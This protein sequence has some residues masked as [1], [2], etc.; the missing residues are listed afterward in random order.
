MNKR[1]IKTKEKKW[2]IKNTVSE[3]SALKISEI[4]ESLGINPIIANLLYGRG[5]QDVVSA[6]KFLYMESEILTDPYSMVDMKPAVER[7]AE[8]IR[9]NEKI[10]IYGDY[11]VDGVTSVC[12]L[13]LY[14]KSY[15]ADVNYY[16]PN[17]IGDG[18]G[19]SEAAISS[20]A[21]EGTKLIIT[22]D[23]GIT[24]DAEV[25]FAKTVGVDFVI[26][27]HHECRQ[28]LP[29]ASAVVNPHRPD[30]PSKFKELAGVGVV[31][32]LL[33]ACEEVFAKKSSKDA[34]LSIVSQY[35]DLVAI[36]TIADVMPIKEENRLIVSY[37]LSMME[38]SPR[39]GV[40]A[41]VEA[42]VGK[43]EAQRMA[44]KRKRTKI[45]SGYIGYTLAPRINA[46]GR[47]RSASI[48]VELFLS[49]DYES[50]YKIAE[51]L[52]EANRERQNEENR[53]IEE[54]FKKIEKNGYDNMPVIVLDADNWHHG[55]I[56]IVSSRITEKYS[57][58]SILVSF[59]GNNSDTPQPT[60]IGKGSGR[61]IKGMNLVDALC[62]CSDKLVKFGGHE[63]AAG[64]SVTR[65][66]L[67]AFREKINEYA[68]ST[69]T[70]EDMIPTA[71]ADIEIELT[72]ANIEL[73]DELRILEPY[74][75]GNPIPAFV[76]RGATLTEISPISE[77]KHTR[78]AFTDGKRAIVGM[79]FSCRHES[80]GLYVGDRVD[81]LFNIDVNEW[82]GRRNVQLIVRDIKQSDSTRSLMQREYDRF[83]EIWSGARFSPDEEIL[84]T[85]DDFAVVY[86][87]L[88]ASVRSGVDTLTVRDIIFRLS[89]IKD[90]SKIGYV[91][92]LVII[93]VMQELNLMGITET[94]DQTYRF[95][96]QY[97]SGKTELDKSNLLRRLRSQQNI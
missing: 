67:D 94:D 39:I 78:F 75:V 57:R 46:A 8:A 37:G 41:L 92:L 85:R 62:Y 2:L 22:V 7:I 79:F 23:T 60:D 38:R 14:L 12:T 50:A 36:G 45:T 91:K 52:C 43:N 10:T 18:Y 17:R 21:E 3:E 32:K 95:S 66:N 49:S 47:I 30:C 4:S 35:A 55:V 83:E 63:L 70:E 74:G 82:A 89:Q 87:M 68:K 73:A 96:I 28:I 42:A 53:I 58:P 27:D 88:V 56:G 65:E 19:V 34:A 93:K 44:N 71:S 64:L 1:K 81:V 9:K 80:L 20:L 90:A 15:G 97:K 5:Y 48:A 61:S 26:T 13:Y 40:M 31:F 84:P 72:D 59:E 16:I 69:L 33:C 6:K 29:E 11:D 86:R 54:A 77:G 51:E 24:A 25:A 76:I